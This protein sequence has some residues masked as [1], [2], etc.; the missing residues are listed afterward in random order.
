MR[1]VNQKGIDLVDV[2]GA[3]G[4]SPDM[5]IINSKHV[6]I[7]FYYYRDHRD[8]HR[9]DRRQRQMCIRDNTH[10]HTLTHTHTHAH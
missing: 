8:L 2:Y 3:S 4:V 10:T 5:C 6:H 7:F 9:V 1:L